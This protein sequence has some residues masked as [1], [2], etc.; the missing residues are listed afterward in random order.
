M[1]VILD[2]RALETTLPNVARGA[3]TTVIVPCVGDGERQK[4]TADALPR[5]GL[6]DQ[7]IMIGHQTIGKE[8][9][10]IAFLR[11]SQ[12]I[13]KS[14]IVAALKK[15]FLAVIAAIECVINQS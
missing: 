15:D 11:F 9:E 4:D 3:A 5:L 12:T 7:M 1:T 8:P 14:Q 2:H 6:Q 10:G 13:K